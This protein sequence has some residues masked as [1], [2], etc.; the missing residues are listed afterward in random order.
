MPTYGTNYYAGVSAG[1]YIQYGNVVATGEAAQAYSNYTDWFKITVVGV[2]AAD[3]ILRQSGVYQNGTQMPQ[4]DFTEDVETAST[5]KTIPLGYFFAIA[6][7][8]VQGDNLTLDSPTQITSTETQPLLGTNRT[9]NVL[10]I[11]DTVPGYYQSQ[12]YAVYDQSSG[13]L[14]ELTISLTSELYPTSGYYLSFNATGTNV[15]ET[16]QEDGTQGPLTWLRDNLL[17]VVLS[18]IAVI[19]IISAAIVLR[20]KPMHDVKSKLEGRESRPKSD[21]A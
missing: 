13:L 19:A 12:T 14:F 18:V 2:G 15:F 4:E 5:N 8:L 10:N 6:S 11:T 20:R 1:E 16:T 7:A 17:Y 3:V 9:V 21:F